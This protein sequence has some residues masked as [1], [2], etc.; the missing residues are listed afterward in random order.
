MGWLPMSVEIAPV[1]EATEL[2]RHYGPTEQRLRALDRVTLSVERGEIVAVMGPSGS[3]K[4]TLLFLLG[5]LDLPDEG[6]VRLS[7]VDW[8]TLHGS[9]RARF[10][11]RTCGFMVQGLALL[12]QATAAENV[13]VPLL[14]DRVEQADRSRRVA[15]ALE[16]V[17]L[18]GHASQLTDELSGGEQQRVSIARALVLEPAVVLADEPTGSLDSVTAQIV[19]R[20]LVDAARER[21]A[22]VVLVTHDPAVAGH[23]DRIVTLHSGRL[24]SDETIG[25]GRRALS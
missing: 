4:S 24:A 3:G 23:A 9:D 1:V 5:G 18:A 22:A 6:S 17:G 14:L 21:N 13:E 12:P 15:E 8:Q 19:T 11:R 20:L 10:L 7:G 16:R 25:S 2:S